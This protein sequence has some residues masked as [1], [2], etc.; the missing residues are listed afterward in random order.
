VNAV[1]TVGYVK[2]YP[3]AA[4]DFPPRS[5]VLLGHLP[6]SLRCRRRRFSQTQRVRPILPARIYE[7][8]G[9]RRNV[10]VDVT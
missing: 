10:D 2:T 1:R 8:E 7:D 6:V 4:E 9:P 5:R 3:P